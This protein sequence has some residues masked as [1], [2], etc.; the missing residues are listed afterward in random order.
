MPAG[1]D[2]KI[3]SRLEA[4]E[5]KEAPL[6]APLEFYR[7][8][9]RIQTEAGSR[10]NMPPPPGPDRQ[11]A[12]VRLA[13]GTPLLGFDDLAVDW[14]LLSDTFAGTVA[15]LAE[16]PGLFGGASELRR[17]LAP[18]LLQE[19]ARAWFE[20]RPLPPIPGDGINPDALE[21]VIH[22]SLRPFLVRGGEATAGLVAQAEWRRGYCPVCGG[23]PDFAFLDREDGARWLVCSRCDAQ[24]LFQR[25]ECPYC[26]NQD[27]GRLAYFTDDQGLYRLYVCE[28]C[29]CYLKA[30]DLRR[31]GADVLLPL[32]RYLTLHLDAQAHRDGYSAYATSDGAVKS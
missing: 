12:A 21:I 31:A 18:E 4:W 23:S 30:I 29:R 16:Y 19:A 2:R 13:S 17:E 7:R 20:G 1:T 28:G 10:I 27:Q 6:A 15:L 22:A 25:L 24:W 14:R 11:A 32:E 5:R 3:L 26:G 8:L 9:L